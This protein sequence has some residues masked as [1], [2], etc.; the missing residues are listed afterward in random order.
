MGIYKTW[1]MDEIHKQNEEKMK[2]GW[3]G[4]SKED[5]AKKAGIICEGNTIDYALPC[6]WVDHMRKKYGTEDLEY[7]RFVGTTVMVYNEENRF[8]LP[9]SFCTEMQAILDKEFAP[10]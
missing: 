10:I 9:T 2:G 8:G 4:L 3:N 6:Q 5:Y 7:Q 1:T